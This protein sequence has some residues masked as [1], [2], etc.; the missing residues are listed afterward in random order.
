MLRKALRLLLSPTLL[1][2]RIGQKASQ[3][4]RLA[5]LRHSPAGELNIL[6]IDC[7]ELLDVAKPLGIGVA[8][9]I[10]AN[11][12]AWTLLVKSVMPACKVEAFE[13]LECYSGWS[14]PDTNFHTVALGAFNG[15]ADMTVANFA[16]ASSLLPLSNNSRT[17][18]GMAEKE[19]VAVDVVKLDDYRRAKNLPF[20]DLIKLDVQGY[21]LEVLKGGVECLAAA[22]AVIAEVAF[23]EL[24]E[25]QPMFHDVVRFMADHGLFVA[26]MGMNAVPGAKLLYADL[27]FV[28]TA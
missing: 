20:P 1:M 8:Y 7:L 9:D 11:S 3:L 23:V 25:G 19:R 4:R 24:Y 2:E 14:I 22:S 15:K 28:R 26:A 17:L 27:L 16:D 13:P 5:R 6:Q 21:E 12:G 18:L 10:G